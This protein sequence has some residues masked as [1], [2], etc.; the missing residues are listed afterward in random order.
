VASACIEG[1]LVEIKPRRRHVCLDS[2]HHLVPLLREFVG[3]SLANVAEQR[4]REEDECE[5]DSRHVVK[6]RGFPN[7]L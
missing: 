3:K 5:A 7:M 4:E 1:L 6:L 2:R